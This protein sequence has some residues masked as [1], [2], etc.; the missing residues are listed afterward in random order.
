M[1]TNN[2]EIEMDK[3]ERRGGNRP[4]A[5]RKGKNYVS[6]SVRLPEETRNQITRLSIQLGI[7]LGETIAQAVDK[8]TETK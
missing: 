1:I 5:G 2:N 8:M 6:M 4:G 7:T 3:I